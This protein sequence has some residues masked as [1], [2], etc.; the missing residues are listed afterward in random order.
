MPPQRPNYEFM[1]LQRL[2]RVK[3]SA[4]A[5][6]AK[7]GGEMV[8]FFKQCVEKRQTKLGKIAEV[9]A[10]LVPVM[11]SEHCSLEALNR[12]TLT[13]IVDSS[14]Q[15]YEVRQLLLA[16]LEKQILLACKAAGLRKIVLKPG[17]WYEGDRDKKLKF[18]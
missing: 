3:E 1:K 14:A 13:V 11:F 12:G 17:R 4:P 18:D 5:A 16:G 9:W 2:Q 7:L 6:A 8:T 10:R 15:L